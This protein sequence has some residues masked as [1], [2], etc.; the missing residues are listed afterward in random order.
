M[1]IGAGSA[2]R[3]VAWGLAHFGYD[4]VWIRNR[5]AGKAAKLAK[6][7]AKTGVRVLPQGPIPPVDI[8]INATP[9]GMA[10]RPEVEIDLAP[11]PDWAIVYDLVYEPPE[12]GLLK[13]ARERGLRTLNG[14]PMLI[15]QARP[16]FQRLFGAMPPRDHDEE[17]MRLV[18]S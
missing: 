16:S 2:A 11:L 4:P 6:D 14:L 1:I 18:T 5:D 7:Y 10:G 13:R 12:T 9:L 3:L 15:E 17:L 8:L